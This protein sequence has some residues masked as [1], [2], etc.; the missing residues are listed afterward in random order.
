MFRVAWRLRWIRFR[1]WLL[2]FPLQAP[3]IMSGLDEL[4]DLNEGKFE[5]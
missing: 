3:G 2:G 1:F 5:K 4:I